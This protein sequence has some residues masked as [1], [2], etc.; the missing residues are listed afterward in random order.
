MKSLSEEKGNV[1][2]TKDW[3][4]EGTGSIHT[5]YLCVEIIVAKILW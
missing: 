5:N 4:I 1:N 2:K 3:F